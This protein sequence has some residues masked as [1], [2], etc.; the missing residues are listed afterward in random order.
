MKSTTVSP[1]WDEGP[2]SNPRESWNTKRGL[3]GNVISF[4]MSCKPRYVSG[5]A[6]EINDAGPHACLHS[7]FLEI[8][9]RS[10]RRRMYVGSL[11]SFIGKRKMGRTI[12][13][14]GDLI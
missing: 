12:S 6:Q 1:V 14:S 13:P 10:K 4:R 7:C 9:H 11:P 8:A 5:T 2:D 3:D